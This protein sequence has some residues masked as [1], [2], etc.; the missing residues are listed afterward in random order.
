VKKIL[1]LKNVVIIG[2]LAA[3]LVVSGFNVP[4]AS[5]SS[6]NFNLMVF[7]G[8]NGKD[9]GLDKE[10]PVNVFVN[11]ALAIPDFQFGEK[12]STSL[13]AGWYTIT[14]QLLDGTPLSSMTVGPVD[15]PA[16]VDVDIKAR[17]SSNGTPYLQ[18]GISETPVPPT[19][20]KV[21]VDHNINGTDLGTLKDLPVNVFIN[22]Q[23]AIPGF[24]FG[25]QIAT[26][27]PAGTYTITVEL[28]D[29]T[30]LPTMTVG[31]VDIPA[32]AHIAIKARLVGD[33]IPVL[34]VNVNQ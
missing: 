5:A 21:S 27:L 20:F 7:H 14:V 26:K 6:G 25:D 12:I 3:V 28:L 2:I 29:G 15:I 30:P 34:K 1:S 17:L 9:L 23:L 13:S 4:V 32:G 24:E 16:G 11:G 18:V 33:N 31:P 19:N 8:I 10:L 22:G